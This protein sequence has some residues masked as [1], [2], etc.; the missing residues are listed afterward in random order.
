[1]GI[2]EFINGPAEGRTRWLRPSCA[3]TICRRQSPTSR[4]VAYARLRVLI[5]CTQFDVIVAVPADEA[6]HRRNRLGRVAPL[7]H[8]R[9]SARAIY[10]NLIYAILLADS[11]DDEALAVGGEMWLCIL[12]AEGLTGAPANH[13]ATKAF[14]VLR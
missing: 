7:Q 11:Y 8:W 4:G 9:K 13:D 5:Q 2:A 6:K 12:D 3:L 10:G 1:M 14:V